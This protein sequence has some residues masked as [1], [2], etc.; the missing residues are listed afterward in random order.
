MSRSKSCPPLPSTYSL[1]LWTMHF[2]H[3]IKQMPLHGT[4]MWLR[5]WKVFTMRK[6]A[7]GPAC[8]P[9][10][11][12]GL[13][14]FICDAHFYNKLTARGDWSTPLIGIVFPLWPLVHTDRYCVSPPPDSRKLASAFVPRRKWDSNVLIP[15]LSAKE[16]EV[17]RTRPGH[18]IT[19]A[20]VKRYGNSHAVHLTAPPVGGGAQ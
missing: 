18:E 5:H 14:L 2:F 12:T 4:T 17:L 10:A 19:V 16:Q 15:W 3:S 9:F 20:R 6:E 1:L 7:L 13:C 8:L 11:P